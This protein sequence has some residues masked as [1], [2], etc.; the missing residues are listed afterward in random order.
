MITLDQFQSILSD[1]LFAGD[2]TVAGVVI[3]SVTLAVIFVVLGKNLFASLLLAIP[4]AFVFS[5]MGVI[6]AD[7]LVILIIVCVL[8]LVMVGK[9]TLGD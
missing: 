5:I 1:S 6:S 3:F 7:L 8:G 4:V 9:R 2:M